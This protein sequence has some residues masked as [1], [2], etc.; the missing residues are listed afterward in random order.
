MEASTRL[1]HRG[2]GGLHRRPPRWL[3]VKDSSLSLR[4]QRER[5]TASRAHTRKG[6]RGHRL[7]EGFKTLLASSEGTASASGGVDVTALGSLC[8]RFLS[9]L[10][11]FPTLLF[12]RGLGT[13]VKWM[14]HTWGMHGPDVSGLPGARRSVWKGYFHRAYRAMENGR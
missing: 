6:F 4:Q 5:E 10:V 11:S 1:N 12:G 8:C 3:G 7:L 14:R 13:L 2:H 9:V